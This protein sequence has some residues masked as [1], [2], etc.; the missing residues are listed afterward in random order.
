MVKVSVAR[1]GFI[2]LAAI[3]ALLYLAFAMM[4]FLG[5]GD[6]TTRLW[7]LCITGITLA[8]VGGLWLHRKWSIRGDALALVAIILAGAIT[9]WSILTPI[10]ALLAVAFWLLSWRPPQHRDLAAV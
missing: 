10:L 7:G 8:I 4:L 9:W 5:V 3:Q 6:D 2:G 1:K